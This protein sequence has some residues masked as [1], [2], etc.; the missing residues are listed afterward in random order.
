MGILDGLEAVQIGHSYP[1]RKTVA[2]RSTQFVRGPGVD[3]T[4]VRQTR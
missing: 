1:N 4:P 3:R 2:R